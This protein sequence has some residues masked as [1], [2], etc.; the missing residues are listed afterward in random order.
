MNRYPG[1]NSVIIMDNCRIHHDADLITLL[2]RDYGIVVEFLPS[3]S[4]DYNPIEEAFACVKAWL[5]RYEHHY[6]ELGYTP[7]EILQLSM[8]V[9]T[10][11]K[12]I[13]YYR[14]AGY[15]E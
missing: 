9:V 13:G 6:R 10:D 2:R 14:H 7:L 11:E 15:S 12:A 1:P 3:Y 4:P 5:R 8:C